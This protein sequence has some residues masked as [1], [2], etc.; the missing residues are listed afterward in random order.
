ML[1]KDVSLELEQAIAGLIAEGKEPTV[2]LVKTR[3]KTA[4]PM[5]AL[6][7]TIKS[8]KN[9]NRVPKIEVATPQTKEVDRIA[10]LEQQVADLQQ[11]LNALEAKLG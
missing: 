7:R 4:I 2:A 6:I 11:R 8:W 3:L 10:Q 5:P 1:T 9:T